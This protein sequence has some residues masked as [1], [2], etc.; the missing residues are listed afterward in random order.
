MSP[1]LSP[2]H[3]ARRQG[4]NAGAVQHQVCKVCA[5]QL[6]DPRHGSASRHGTGNGESA[7]SMS[8][9]LQQSSLGLM[10]R[11][12]YEQNLPTDPSTGPSSEAGVYKRAAFQYSAFYLSAPAEESLRI[13][14]MSSSLGIISVVKTNLKCYY[15]TVPHRTLLMTYVSSGWVDMKVPTTSQHQSPPASQP[16][17]ATNPP[18]VSQ[19]CRD[20]EPM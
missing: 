18:P 1:G 2:V 17:N 11:D 10:I 5:L 19:Y 12:L 4:I 20:D 14:F 13:E 3:W 16:S 7:A 9:L 8:S 15:S 6:P